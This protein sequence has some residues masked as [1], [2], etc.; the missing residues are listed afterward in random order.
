ML[1]ACLWIWLANSRVVDTHPT[2]HANVPTERIERGENSDLSEP[3]GALH[4]T[5]SVASVAH[6]N[7][8]N[9][10]RRLLITVVDDVGR[11]VEGARISIQTSGT[12]TTLGHSDVGGDLAIGD[13][14]DTWHVGDMIFATHEGWASAWDY[15]GDPLPPII[16][17]Q[18][19]AT[20]SITGAVQWV[21][22]TPSHLSDFH[23]V[24]MPAILM[25]SIPLQGW[26]RL[27]GDPRVLLGSCSDDGSF[28]LIG[29]RPTLDYWVTGGGNGFVHDD[30]PIKIQA[31]GDP[32]M[33]PA[34]PLYGARLRLANSSGIPLQ[35]P[36]VG[37]IENG[38]SE[39]LKQDEVSWCSA[40]A[41]ARIMAGVP[42]SWLTQ[43]SD[44]EV[45]LATYGALREN[46]GP[47]H[48]SWT[49]PGYSPLTTDVHLPFIAAG[50]KEI[51]VSAQVLDA[52]SSWIEVLFDLPSWSDSLSVR[53]IGNIVLRTEAGK[54]LFLPVQSP[55]GKRALTGPLPSGRYSWRF[56]WKPN[57]PQLSRTHQAWNTLD[58]LPGLTT[59]IVIDTSRVGALLLELSDSDGRP[60][61]GPVSAILGEARSSARMPGRQE[62]VGDEIHFER[63]P[64][65]VPVVFSGPLD[66]KLI[67]PL[68]PGTVAC[69]VGVGQQ[70]RAQITI[71]HW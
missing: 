70:Y 48:V 4:P 46:V 49:M 53:S 23:V 30:P 56:E 61:T 58:L 15:I 12:A 1:G 18:L 57:S 37:G 68:R 8:V 55:D 7:G 67:C 54:T 9:T 64:Y 17:L 43:E 60:Y 29:A 3:D 31:G 50:A 21:S 27:L 14:C 11:G 6:P 39:D 22:G 13:V 44:S 51:T 62:M 16:T 5:H 34:S 69:V 19:R 32:I 38:F 28:R 24:A 10:K 41:V 42:A 47:V 33:L 25:G 35:L 59:T 2:S 71:P 45:L 20:L 66:V 36:I 40:H 26:E 65:L 52:Q 63:P